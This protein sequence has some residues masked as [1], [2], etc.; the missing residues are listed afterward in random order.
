MV[1]RKL[2]EQP[3]EREKLAEKTSKSAKYSCLTFAESLAIGKILT[4]GTKTL[5]KCHFEPFVVCVLGVGF[6]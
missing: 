2:S 5:T 6:V 4:G 1:R 3:E